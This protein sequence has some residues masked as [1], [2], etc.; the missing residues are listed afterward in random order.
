[1]N[2]KY[3][4]EVDLEGKR[5]TKKNLIPGRKI[6]EQVLRIKRV[7]VVIVE[8]NPVGELEKCDGKTENEME[9]FATFYSI[10]EQE[11]RSNTST[12]SK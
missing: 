5:K 8:K 6:K 1:M 4:I 9:K 7:M 10:L 2:E 11:I 12:F 3:P